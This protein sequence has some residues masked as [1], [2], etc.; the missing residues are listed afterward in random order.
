MS[1]TFKTLDALTNRNAEL[2][3]QLLDS[4]CTDLRRLAEVLTRLSRASRAEAVVDAELE[5]KIVRLD[6]GFPG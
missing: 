5:R 2:V 6:R 4:G 1:E 3:G